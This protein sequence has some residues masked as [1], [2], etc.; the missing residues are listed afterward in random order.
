[1]VFTSSTLE[2]ELSSQECYIAAARKKEQDLYNNELLSSIILEQYLSGRE[3]DVL[4]AREE[5]SELH[6]NECAKY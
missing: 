4:T 6:I 5:E 3:C 2:R 1:M